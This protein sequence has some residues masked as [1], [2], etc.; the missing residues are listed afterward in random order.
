MYHLWEYVVGDRG[1]GHL[2]VLTGLRPGDLLSLTRANQTDD[3]I[4][5][6]TSKTGK[7]LLIEWS[8]ALRSA[9]SRA[10]SLPMTQPVRSPLASVV[11]HRR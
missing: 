3:G 1:L 4:E 7:R 6:L 5:I 9:V 10:E 11:R 8:D 2:A